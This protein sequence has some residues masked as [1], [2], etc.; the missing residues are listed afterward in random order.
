[1]APR[2][3][4]TGGAGFIGSQVA[5]ELY[6]RHCFAD[7]DQARHQLGFEPRVSFEQGLQKLVQWLAC[8]KAIDRV[9]QATEELARRGLVA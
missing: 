8:A 2:V 6:V 7:I 4:I 1:M 9:D 3:L 5:D